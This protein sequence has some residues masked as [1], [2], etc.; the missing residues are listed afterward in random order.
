MWTREA[1]SEDENHRRIDDDHRPKAEVEV[2]QLLLKK[3]IITEEE[4]R[5]A[6]QP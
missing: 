1:K 4:W 2:Q 3:G 5:K 6:L